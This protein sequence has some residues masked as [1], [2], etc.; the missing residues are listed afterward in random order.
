M[1][2]FASG[3]CD[4]IGPPEAGSAPRKGDMFGAR[5]RC[6]PPR[7]AKMRH[8]YDS[9]LACSSDPSLASVADP[10]PPLHIMPKHTYV[11]GAS[12]MRG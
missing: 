12:T 9:G 2:T 6:K 4:P 5:P 10:V 8:E 7:A 3:E 1:N 11:L